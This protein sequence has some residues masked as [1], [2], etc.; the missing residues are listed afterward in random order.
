MTIAQQLN[1]TTFPFEIKD[2]NGRLTYFE[3]SNGYWCKMEFDQYGNQIYY[4]NSNG[5]I[6]DIRPKSETT[7]LGHWHK[8]GDK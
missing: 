2:K 7:I 3:E 5:Y 1:I 8:G 6:K 4:E